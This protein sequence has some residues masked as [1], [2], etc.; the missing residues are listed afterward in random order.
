MSIPY[1][2]GQFDWQWVRGTTTPVV[3]TLTKNDQPMPFDDVRLSVY[4]DNGRTLAFR[5]STLEGTMQVTDP[6]TAQIT[7]TPTSEQTRG[8]S[9]SKIGGDPKNRYE[10]E[11]RENGSEQVYLLGNITAIGGLNDD[12]AED[13]S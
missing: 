6:A 9:E 2:P 7:F 13:I 10:L 4:K 5:V 12:D 11:V 3:F 8:L 1:T